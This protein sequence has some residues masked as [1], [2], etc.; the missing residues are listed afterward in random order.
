[1]ADEP[2]YSSCVFESGDGIVVDLSNVAEAK[3]ENVPKG[4]YDFE[5]ASVEYKKSQQGSPMLETWLQIT[6]PAGNPAIGR[7]LPHYLVF[8]AKALPF[9]KAAINRIEDGAKIFS[10]QVNLQQ[11]ADSGALLGKRARA[12]VGIREYEGQ[13]RS[14]ISQFLPIQTDGSAGQ[15]TAKFA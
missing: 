5:F 3:F 9:T 10:G 14:N 13:D 8:S 7:K 4:V 15:A 11:V 2:D 6:G 12:R 1:M